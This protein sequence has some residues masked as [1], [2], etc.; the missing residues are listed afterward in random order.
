MS[1]PTVRAKRPGFYN[2]HRAEGER[3]PLESA[4]DF[5]P[6]WMEAVDRVPDKAATPAKGA[7]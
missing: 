1:N 7:K 4:D 6:S 3:F 2:G 5:A